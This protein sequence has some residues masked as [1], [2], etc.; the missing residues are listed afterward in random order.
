MYTE[1]F[2]SIP[3]CRGGGRDDAFFCCQ[4]PTV[5]NNRGSNKIILEICRDVPKSFKSFC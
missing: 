4:I 2:H 5:G 1:N 3:L